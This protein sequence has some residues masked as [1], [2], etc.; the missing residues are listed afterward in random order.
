[1]S[2][3]DSDSGRA[4]RSG[5]VASNNPGSSSSGKPTGGGGGKKRRQVT[6]EATLHRMM[7]E[8]RYELDVDPYRGM[9]RYAKT[10]H[11][12]A[13]EAEEDTAAPRA[14][15]FAISPWESSCR[16]QAPADENQQVVDTPGSTLVQMVCLNQC[17]CLIGWTDQQMQK[18][19]TNKR[20]KG[21]EDPK[22]AI[23]C[24]PGNAQRCRCDYN[25]FCLGTLGGVMDEVWQQRLQTIAGDTP[26]SSQDPA[27]ENNETV[28]DLQESSSED[29][30]PPKVVKEKRFSPDPN[31]EESKTLYNH[32]TYVKLQSLRSSTLVES[33]MIRAYLTATLQDLTKVV[34][35]D[36]CMRRIEDWNKELLFANPLLD[37]PIEAGQMRLAFPPGIENLGATCYLN[38]Q[39]QCLAQIDVFLK[40]IFTW[41]APPTQNDDKVTEVLS[42]FQR[43]LASLH[44]GAQRQITTVEFSN[45]LGI[46]H[47]EQ[48]DPNEFSRLFFDFM[49]TKFKEE[50]SGG[51]GGLSELLPDLFQG[52]IKNQIICQKCSELSER[53]EPFM[54]LNLPIVKRSEEDKVPRKTG[55]QSI[56]ECLG[57]HVDTDVQFLFDLYCRDEMLEGDNQYFCDGCGCKQDACRR[58][59]FEKVPPIL[60]VQLSR[61]IFDIKTLNKKKVS[62]KVLLPLELH[63]ESEREGT[64][65]SAKHRYVLCAVMVHKGKS[66]YSGHYIAQ[67]VNW[68]TG[69]WF[70]FN[71]THV[72]LLK[73]GPEC[74]F[75]PTTEGG[76]LKKGVS[77]SQDAY[78]LY[79]VEES[80]LAQSIV[81]RIQSLESKDQSF[82]LDEKAEERAE[83]YSKLSDACIKNREAAER[84]KKRREDIL[85]EL[86]RP[87]RP[88]E[89]LVDHMDPP[90][91]WVPGDFL[92]RFFSCT[93]P[94]EVEFETL[95]CDVVEDLI[96]SSENLCHHSQKGLHPRVARKGKLLPRVMYE[97]IL[98]SLFE[99]KAAILPDEMNDDDPH[100]F[101]VT[102]SE[103]IF[104]QECVDEF[105]LD[106]RP[107]LDLLEDYVFLYEELDTKSEDAPIQYEAGTVFVCEEDKYVYLVARKFCSAL[108]DH[109]K[110]IMKKVAP[111][112]AESIPI[113]EN[114]LPQYE[115]IAEGLETIEMKDIEV[116]ESSTDKDENVDKQV[117][118]AITCPHGV[119]T[120][121]TKQIVRFVSWKVWQRIVKVFPHAIEH[122]LPRKS[123]DQVEV[124]EIPE[125]CNLCEENESMIGN[126]SKQLSILARALSKLAES[127]GVDC[128]DVLFSDENETFHVVHVDEWKA[129]KRFTTTFRRKPAKSEPRELREEVIRCLK[130]HE[131]LVHVTGDKSGDSGSL[132]EIDRRTI[133]L[134]S[135]LVRP[136]KCSKH[137]MPTL[138]S[139]TIQHADQ[140]SKISPQVRILDKTSYRKYIL[141]LCALARILILSEEG[142]DFEVVDDNGE[143][144][145]SGIMTDLCLKKRVFDWH[146]RLASCSQCRPERSVIMEGKS[147]SVSMVIHSDFC[148]EN[149]CH[150][151]LEKLFPQDTKTN[152][153]TTTKSKG[154]A[155]DPIMIDVDPTATSA[156]TFPLAV[157]E[158]ESSASEESI[159]N[160]LTNYSSVSN[161]A[162]K[163]PI[164]N[165]LRRSSRRRKTRFPTGVLTSEDT[166]QVDIC[167]NI[168]AL[169]LLL[170]ESCSEGTPFSPD[171]R[172][173]LVVS[174]V[175][176]RAEPDEKEVKRSVPVP[177]DFSLNQKSL[178]EI[179]DQALG[180]L[181]DFVP[182]DSLVLVRQAIVLEDTMDIGKDDLITDL[183]NLSNVSSSDSSGKKRKARVVEKGFTGTL[184]SAGQGNGNKKTRSDDGKE[185]KPAENGFHGSMLSN[186]PTNTSESSSNHGKEETPTSLLSADPVKCRSLVA[187][188]NNQG[189]VKGD[190]KREEP[191]PTKGNILGN[192]D[193]RDHTVVLDEPDTVLIYDDTKEDEEGNRLVLNV[194]ESL[195][196]NPGVVEQNTDAVWKASKW[197]VEKNPSMR[198]AKALADH[199]YAKYLELTMEWDD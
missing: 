92:R 104:C 43:I 25:P 56:L 180:G 69:C 70:E 125:E 190:F 19:K 41:K 30:G 60:N 33:K 42:R 108:R 98:G 122:R 22:Q 91:V 160:D 94:F 152:G 47:F 34:S 118:N 26:T 6:G 48:Q 11:Q 188:D 93:D 85:N 151:E 154:N 65:Q 17:P 49:H 187:V 133:E 126:L 141:S 127:N 147:M 44:A 46:D 158:A 81:E 61:Y 73:G 86:F 82:V 162:E 175:D 59:R 131:T 194:M 121:S 2:A 179:C 88:F 169:R 184:L 191:S 52:M 135:K 111:A 29:N 21:A 107:K 112:D 63:V 31:L 124:V 9:M 176:T 12:S 110:Q 153:E 182:K 55:Q 197:S 123:S 38:T 71:D 109:I 90:P 83:L 96:K 58:V 178:V 5:S 113:D 138:S 66:A 20:K 67:A 62:E 87:D 139:L 168:A 196:A 79:Y 15:A 54:D 57:E 27:V 64:G 146:P 114:L 166:V 74:S 130:P 128:D 24:R 199:A 40:G 23:G 137:R 77:G 119:C 156:D 10:N 115:T 177:L 163:D 186:G 144:I 80:F 148:C 36:K 28:I 16:S 101:V 117:N 53:K 171:H 102:P 37:A 45:A 145:S 140:K 14:A 106:I 51:P 116:E 161:G 167:N 165:G 159:M 155:T 103:N 39:L 32:R 134:V 170:Y 3:S 75:D 174:P 142:C 89:A 95:G 100:G 97:T 173:L 132:D 198:D 8:A 105:H 164:G 129:F 143:I 78:N 18:K 185:D 4:L 13:Q 120:R 195:K 1:M 76:M 99:E 7:N 50:D 72:K 172:L 193:A 149:E 183:I 150:E 68:V 181:S 84:L 192:G 189:D 136:L 35:I 157:F